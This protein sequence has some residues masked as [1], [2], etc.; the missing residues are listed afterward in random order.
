MGGSGIGSGMTRFEISGCAGSVAVTSSRAALARPGE[1]AGVVIRSRIGSFPNR[2]VPVSPGKRS[3]RTGTTTGSGS[4]CV[5]EPARRGSGAP[6]P[7]RRNR[8]TQIELTE[9]GLV[10][11]ATQRVSD[12]IGERVE[13]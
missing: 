11:L 10:H 1:L 3:G 9:I 7:E 6:G 12:P 13:P 2:V 4:G 8:R 5:G